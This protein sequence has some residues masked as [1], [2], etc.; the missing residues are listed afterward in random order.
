M[1][2][3]L[4]LTL[5]ALLAPRPATPAPGATTASRVNV[6]VGP[7]GKVQY[8]PKANQAIFLGDPLVRVKRGDATLLC[9]KLVAQNFTQGQVDSA[10]CTGD[11]RLEHGEQTV[12]CD[13][14]HF[15]NASGRLTC[16][17]KLVVVHDG[18]SVM[19]G[20]LLTYDLDS[21]DAELSGNVTG[22]L[23]PKPGQE[24]VRK[25]KAEAAP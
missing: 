5:W 1:S 17:G 16:R 10:D 11:V 23:V 2:A 4:L 6:D 21:G 19:R 3:Q 7:A 22:E 18:Q 13:T 15:E 20:T 8:R 9:R 24:P 25:R 14:A 12:T